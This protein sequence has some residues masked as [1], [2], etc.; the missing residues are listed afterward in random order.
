MKDQDLQVITTLTLLTQLQLSACDLY[1]IDP[2]AKSVN[3]KGIKIRNLVSLQ[4]LD[5]SNNHLKNV[6]RLSL[7]YNLKELY[8][9]RNEIKNISKLA[10]LV[11]LQLLDVNTNYGY[12]DKY[13]DFL[14]GLEKLTQLNIID[15]YTPYKLE[16]IK[17]FK[18]RI[19]NGSLQISNHYKLRNLKFISSFNLQ[20]LTIHKC[21]IQNLSLA[22]SV[23]EKYSSV[24]EL[25]IVFC[26]IQDLDALEFKDV[27]ILNLEG[28]K[29]KTIR[30][31]CILQHLETF[32]ISKNKFS[33]ISFMQSSPLTTFN[34]QHNTIK[35]TS[36]LTSLPKLKEL[37]L[38]IN[39]DRYDYI[40]LNPLLHLCQLTKLH[41]A[42][43][44]AFNIEILRP[45]TNLEELNI[46]G[47]TN[48]GTYRLENQQKLIVLNLS[49]IKDSNVKFDFLKQF[50]CLKEL[51]LSN[52]RGLDISNLP[53]QLTKL[54]I[55]NTAFRHIS[56]IQDIYKLENLQYFDFHHIN[57]INL[58]PISQM[59]RLKHLNLS[60]CE[61]NSIQDLKDL[62]NLEE[63]D[64]SFN[65]VKIDTEIDYFIQSIN[66]SV[67]YL[68][69]SLVKLNLSN[70]NINNLQAIK[71]LVN[72]KELELNENYRIEITPLQYLTQLTKL[73]LK[74]CQIQNIQALMPLHNLEQLNLQKNLIIDISPLKQM[75]K[76]KI[77]SVASNQIFNFK[78][79]QHLANFDEF[80]IENQQHFDQQT[81]RDIYKG[82][83]EQAIYTSVNIFREIGIKR[84]NQKQIYLTIK[85]RVEQMFLKQN[86][87]NASFMRNAS[88]F[89]QQTI[90]D[91]Q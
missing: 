23:T 11:R 2:L 51:N 91:S 21:Q 42:D 67:I 13:P 24:T 65:L 40:D 72:L 27:K 15:N 14:G 19:I 30:N 29:L 63:L 48:M 89:F 53:A 70:S 26:D 18:N 17:K 49:N 84:K 52:N 12:E 31:F 57:K 78:A 55:V 50:K 3:I 4:Y 58:S 66:I 76:L 20:K 71:Q 35:D 82:N 88:F 74:D 10:K 41:I 32:N 77:L 54:T 46:S 16:V 25:N 80:S 1:N 83:A 81:K 90:V 61:I 64:I 73:G 60:K 38:S 37:F 59:C 86:M 79:I 7:F 22:Q 8:I 85:H 68:F 47:C 6:D 45:L 62:T 34:A 44:G 39:E 56:N 33:D 43:C 36:V 28:N 9:G 75:T 5:V 87:N 69:K